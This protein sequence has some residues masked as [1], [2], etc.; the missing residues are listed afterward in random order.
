MPDA[1]V[2]RPLRPDEFE[3]FLARVKAGYVHDMVAAGVDP[4]VALAKS[5]RDHATLLPDGLA[6]DGHL[7]FALEDEGVPA[8]YLWLSTRE[9]ELGR[10]LFVYGVEVDE[11]HRGRGLG[12]AAMAFAEAE[13]RRLGLP[14]VSLNVFG[15][16]DVARRLYT[17]LGYAETAIAMEK[18]L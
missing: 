15:G 13:A 18:H 8:G 7:I 4:D 16:N 12:R 17:S 14:K 5:E 3:A 11:A 2:A 9:S 1:P 10:A 6:S